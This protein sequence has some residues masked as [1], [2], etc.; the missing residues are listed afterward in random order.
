MQRSKKGGGRR[1]KGATPVAY[2]GR[3]RGRASEI[4]I[5]LQPERY[6]EV[7]TLFREY[8]SARSELHISWFGSEFNSGPISSALR[9]EEERK[10]RRIP[11]YVYVHMRRHK[12]PRVS[13]KEMQ[14]KDWERQS[15]RVH[16]H[17]LAITNSK[18]YMRPVYTHDSRSI[19]ESRVQ[20]SHS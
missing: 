17:I 3:N 8:T 15:L 18:G 14:I 16:V 5:D 1:K 13:R 11:T 10:T 20:C 19:P 4:C 7:P 12:G 9:P 6:S 2:S